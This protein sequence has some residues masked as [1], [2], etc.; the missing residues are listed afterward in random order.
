MGNCLIAYSGS[1]KTV[2]DQ[3]GRKRR[4]TSDALGRMIRVIEDPDGQNLATDYVFD[5]LG[6]LRRTIQGEQSRYFMY[7][8]LG[9]LLR[10]KQPEQDANPS[11]AATDP[12][13]GNSQ[14]SV[15]Y[16]YDAN[17]NI[18]STMDARGISITGTYDNLNR[19]TCGII[20]ILRR[21]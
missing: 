9:R 4:G 13:T 15:A 6:N 3:A 21:M 7:D 14:W 1:T 16:A 11:L 19:L 10:A 20:P 12:I 5:T 8:S 2:T 18:T 17:G